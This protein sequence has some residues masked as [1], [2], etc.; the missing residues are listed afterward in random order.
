MR[1][2]HTRVRGSSGPGSSGAGRPGRHRQSRRRVA[3]WSR[4]IVAVLI[5]AMVGVGLSYTGTTHVVTAEAES[6]PTAGATSHS[7]DLTASG[8]RA[9]V[10][11]DSGSRVT[12]SRDFAALSG[13]TLRAKAEVC[14]GSP[15]M[16][17]YVDGSAYQEQD[18]TS[19]QWADYTFSGELP[20]GNHSLAIEFTNGFTAPGCARELIIDR[21]TEIPQTSM[22]S[23]EPEPATTEPSIPVESS[24]CVVNQYRASYFN[25][26]GGSGVPVVSRCESSVGGNWVGSPVAGVNADNFSVVYVGV[27]RF[28]VGGSYVFAADT[29]DSGVVVSV[30][31]VGVIN[32]PGLSTWGRFEVVRAMSAGEHTVRVMVADGSG[33]AIQNFSVAQVGQGPAAGSGSFFARDSFWNTPIP[34]GVSVDERSAGWVSSLM[35]NA[36]ITQITTNSTRWST[37][38]YVAPAGTPKRSI[39]VTNSNKRVSVPYLSSYVA[40][41]DGDAHAA[42]ID[43]ATGCLYEFQGFTGSQA[44]AHASFHA[45]TGSGGHTAGPA[46]AGGEFS[47]LAGMITP[48]DV[49]SGVIDHAIRYALPIGGDR[50]NY[51]G[52]RTDGTI[53]D[54]IPQGA[55]VRLDP[56]V[57]VDTLGLNRF[58]KMVATA[59]QRYGGYNADG[60]AAFSIS[61]QQTGDAGFNAALS[62]LPKS[63]IA[64]LQFLKPSVS[65]VDVRLDTSSDT[66]CNQ[67]Q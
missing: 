13:L 31:G 21:L 29:G 34:A 54:G 62:N 52:T 4:V 44:I 24:G 41:P 35:G 40:S 66:T 64:K 45:Y 7:D 12:Y 43:A 2:K 50:Y 60:S 25:S 51:P 59:L 46:H 65:S 18:V 61:A 8:G 19:E 49:S 11:A 37:P 6:L 56:S 17:I 53:R 23:V 36:A 20:A 32:E 67:Q 39:L 48:Q 47:Y 63:L 33:T 28:P 1:T 27:L 57:D 5:L 26:V 3:T 15:T 16:T 22:P 55:R 9:L 42:I 58:Q 38:V 30:D 14:D 10:L